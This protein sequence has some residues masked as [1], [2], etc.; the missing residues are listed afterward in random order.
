MTAGNIKAVVY[1][2]RKSKYK[3][4]ESPNCV[5]NQPEKKQ[6]SE[7]LTCSLIVFSGI[8]SC[9]CHGCVDQSRS[10]ALNFWS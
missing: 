1:D 7:V 3:A 2:E 5:V 10:L 8:S 9:E 4:I 6:N